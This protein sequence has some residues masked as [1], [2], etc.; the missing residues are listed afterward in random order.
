MRMALSDVEIRGSDKDCIGTWQGAFVG[1]MNEQFNSIK[2]HGINNIKTV[3]AQKEEI[4]HN[5]MNATDKV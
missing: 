2:I 5:Y 3:N 4:I 1:I